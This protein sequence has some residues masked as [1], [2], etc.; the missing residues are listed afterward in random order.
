VSLV[1]LEVNNVVVVVVVA[2]VVVVMDRDLLQS[3]GNSLLY[4][5]HLSLCFPTVFSD[6]Q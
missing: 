5:I 6:D 2:V 4:C 1:M 3:C